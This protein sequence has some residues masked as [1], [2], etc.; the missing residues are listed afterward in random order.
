MVEGMTAGVFF[1]A[2]K[3]GNGY[4]LSERGVHTLQLFLRE[5][6][7]DCIKQLMQSHV[8][9]SYV[10]GERCLCR[11]LLSLGDASLQLCSLLLHDFDLSRRK[12]IMDG[13][14]LLSCWK[15]V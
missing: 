2:N 8:Y 4:R 1:A 7:T 9:Y 13:F 12:L 15:F 3:N 5:H 11:S 14:R 6:G 10:K